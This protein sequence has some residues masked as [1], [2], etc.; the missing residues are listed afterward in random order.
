MI[1]LRCRFHTVLSMALI[2]LFLVPATQAGL[3]DGLIAYYPFNGNANDE[4]GNENHGIAQADIRYVKGHLQEAIHLS[5]ETH[6][7]MHQWV[8]LPSIDASSDLSHALWVK[9]EKLSSSHS[10]MIISYGTQPISSYGILISPTGE[11]SVQLTKDGN[12][13]TTASTN[14]NDGNYHHI[15]ATKKGS[16]LSFFVDG[17]LIGHLDMPAGFTLSND[18]GYLGG[19]VWREDNSSRFN[20]DIDE[21][22][23]Y[24]RALSE[25]EIQQL[26]KKDCWAVYQNGS[27]HLPCVKV[28]GPFSDDLKYEVDM[29]YQ[30][31]SEPMSFQITG[32][33]PK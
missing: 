32:A 12:E 6:T 18:M 27:L 31:S 21:L 29:Q 3:N 5:N 1:R 19:H 17:I 2:G 15:A 14:I 11:V 16:V 10:E 33:K 9:F 30:P 4:S 20:G 7:G 22:R 28:K 24:N 26:H 8:Q 25:L 23:I 13:E